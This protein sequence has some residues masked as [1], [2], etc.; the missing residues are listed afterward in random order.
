M[1]LTLTLAV[2]D[3]ERTEAFYRDVLHLDLERLRAAPGH[4][5]VLHLAVGTADLLFREEGVFAAFHPALFQS[6]ERHPRGLG[7]TLELTLPSLGPVLREIDRRR[8]HTLYE[9]EDDEFGRREV[10]LH[11][12]DGFLLVLSEQGEIR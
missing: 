10:W 7:I 5:P 2:A 12:P 8:L 11:D 3:L 4:P 9:L 6:L 1:D